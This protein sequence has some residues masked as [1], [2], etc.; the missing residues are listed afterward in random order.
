MTFFEAEQICSYISH[1]EDALEEWALNRGQMQSVRAELSRL[2]CKLAGEISGNV[3]P[4]QKELLLGL[5]DQIKECQM[6]ID[7]RLKY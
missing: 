3:K 7:E 5:C 1:L 6:C 4:P 2:G